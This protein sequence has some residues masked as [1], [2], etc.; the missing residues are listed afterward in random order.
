[1]GCNNSNSINSLLI[2]TPLF[3]RVNQSFKLTKLYSFFTQNQ[4][5][6]LLMIKFYMI[7]KPSSDFYKE[8]TNGR[9]FTLSI[10]VML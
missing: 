8:E 7:L 5:P 4:P 10:L 1:M 2:A 9:L 3:F 6:I